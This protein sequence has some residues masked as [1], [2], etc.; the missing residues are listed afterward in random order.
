MI[1]V[2]Q[3]QP[4]RQTQSLQVP[5]DPLTPGDILDAIAGAFRSDE[6]QSENEAV[7]R[8]DGSWLL[9]GWMPVDEMAELLGLDLPEHRHYETVAGFVI[10][11]FERIPATGEAIEIENWRFE[12]VDLDH[13]RVDKVLASRL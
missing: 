6:D 9:A 4:R 1:W 3:Y 10:D 5:G 11:H 12:V 8:D 13:R 7:L 2:I